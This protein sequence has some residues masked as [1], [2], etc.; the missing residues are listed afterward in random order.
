MTNEVKAYMIGDCTLCR[1]G[2]PCLNRSSQQLSSLEEWIIQPF[3]WISSCRDER[4]I[5]VEE[6]VPVAAAA[7]AVALDGEMKLL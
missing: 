6:D 2:S 3:T 1:W 7:S 4:R 5:A